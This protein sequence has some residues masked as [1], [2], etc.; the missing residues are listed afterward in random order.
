[1]S[2]TTVRR[3]LAAS[4]HT[5][6]PAWASGCTSPPS[7]ARPRSACSGAT[8]FVKGEHQ[9]DATAGV[10]LTLMVLAVMAAGPV[11]GWLVGNHPWH[12]STMVPDHRPGH[13]RDVDRGPGVAGPRAHAAAGRAGARGRRRRTGPMIG[14]STSAAPPTRRSGSRAPAASST[15]AVSSPAWSRHRDRPGARLAHTGR[16]HG[17]HAVGVPVGDGDPVPHLGARP[18][19]FYRYRQQARR[20]IDRRARGEHPEHRHEQHRER[21]RLGAPPTLRP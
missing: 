19:R 15:R 20:V 4:W 17:P 6:A 11:L 16:E 14:G 5:R 2:L 3:S 18:R 12:R 8:S 10:L 9:S 13:R 21:S 1:M 7:S